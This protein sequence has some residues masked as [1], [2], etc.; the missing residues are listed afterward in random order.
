MADELNQTSTTSQEA[1]Q[2]EP[3]EVP[4]ERE[5]EPGVPKFMYLIYA[6]VLGFG[7]YYL[8]TQLRPPATLT[9]STPTPMATSALIAASGGGLPDDA[10]LQGG[11]VDNGKD[12]FAKQACSACHVIEA[13]K[14]AT[15]GPNL[16]NIGNRAAARKPG[17]AA[18]QYIWESIL[19]PNAFL[20]PGFGAGIMPQDFRQKLSDQDLKDLIAYLLTLKSGQD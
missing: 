14:P 6:V 11:N 10:A 8:A 9:A 7:I 16:S 19:N 13:G 12:L 17:Y 15:V 5:R 1:P 4:H 18:E 2:E 3:P 20:A